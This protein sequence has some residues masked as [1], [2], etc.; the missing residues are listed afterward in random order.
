MAAAA[1]FLRQPTF[2]FLPNSSSKLNSFSYHPRPN[3]CLRLR[4]SKSGFL[5]GFLS[6]ERGVLGPKTMAE[7][8]K[9]YTF[10]SN[11]NRDEGVQVLE[12][13]V[14]MDD[15]NGLLASG[16]ESILNRL[17]KWLV[18]ALF[19]GV[20]LWRHDAEALWV[21]MGSVINAMLSVVLKRILNQE[22]P[23]ST[24]RSDPGMPSSHA[25][26]IF[27]TSMFAVL[28]VVEWLGIN[29]FSLTI[30]G[31]ILAFGSYLSWLRVSQ[32]LHT[33]SQIGVGAAVGSLF[34]ILWYLFW[35]AIVSEAFAS[36][37]W[38]QI[39]VIFGAAAF[40]LGFVIYVIRYWFR[41]ERL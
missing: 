33:I 25:Q 28:S 13:E 41:D 22:R 12:Q 5:G 35:K 16:F 19:G 10:R 32:R 31:L 11:G 38:V 40:C 15:S 39:V 1:F 4:S 20:I 26:S 3:F 29:E 23:F 6:R 18:A 34:S 7:A 27:Y 37:L 8:F 14:L 21:A 9:C 30:N 24:M 17:S 36:Y 2:N